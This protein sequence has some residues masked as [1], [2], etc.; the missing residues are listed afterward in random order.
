MVSVLIFCMN[1]TF[2]N[3]LSRIWC[4]QE[5][6]IF[7]P[8]L[9][10]Q[11]KRTKKEISIWPVSYISKKKKIIVDCVKLQKRVSLLTIKL[12]LIPFLGKIQLA[13]KL[14]FFFLIQ[15]NYLTKFF[16]HA[17]IIIFDYRVFICYFHFNL[18]NNIW[19][20]LKYLSHYF[21]TNW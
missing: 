5:E 18:Y 11:D 12:Y 21:K 14:I 9:S 10:I 3:L 6:I 1:W 2:H 15:R 16:A 13:L 20:V 8:I 7:W 19:M 4:L 17:W